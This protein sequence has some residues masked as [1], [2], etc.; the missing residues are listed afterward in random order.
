MAPSHST[1][2][3]PVSP[4]PSN[5]FGD[6]NVGINNTDGGPKKGKKDLSCKKPKLSF[7]FK[8]IL[9]YNFKA[10]VGSVF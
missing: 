3:I 5:Y 9:E 7:H 4:D 2:A 10:R 8:M 1:V 6:Y